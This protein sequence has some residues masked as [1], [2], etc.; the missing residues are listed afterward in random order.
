[1]SRSRKI[2]LE[3]NNEMVIL[4]FLLQF[5]LEELCCLIIHLVFELI[6]GGV[7]WI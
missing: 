4:E 6:R 7:S 1:L 3:P 5:L 2:Q